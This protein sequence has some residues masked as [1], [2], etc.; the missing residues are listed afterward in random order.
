[1]A[2]LQNRSLLAAWQSHAETHGFAPLPRD[3]FA[4]FPNERLGLRLQ[5]SVAL[6][7]LVGNSKTTN[8]A[9]RCGGVSRGE[10]GH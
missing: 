3:R 9:D 8:V 10:S 5:D 1:M 4:L 2:L 7:V 6:R